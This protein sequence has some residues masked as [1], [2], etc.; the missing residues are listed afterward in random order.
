MI[1]HVTPLILCLITKSIDAYSPYPECLEEEKG[2]DPCDIQ[3]P[4]ADCSECEKIKAAEKKKTQADQ[5]A[6]EDAYLLVFISIS[7]LL[8]FIITKKICC[9]DKKIPDE[10]IQEVSSPD[11]E[12]QSRTISKKNNSRMFIYS[13]PV[14]ITRFI[15]IFI[16]KMRRT[17]HQPSKSGL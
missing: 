7:V 4:Y 6:R 3:N 16:I 9:K 10:E 8:V 11:L 5:S 14:F 1:R 15:C 17:I 12:H 13:H 2:C